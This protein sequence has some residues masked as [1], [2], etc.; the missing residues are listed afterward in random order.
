VDLAVQNGAPVVASS[1]NEPLIT[2]EWAVAVFKEAKAAGLTTGYVSNGNGTPQVLEYLRPWVDLYKV[3]LKSFDDRHY[4][5]LGGR[6]Q[7]ILDTISRLHAMD[8][9]VEIVTL[10]IPG[11]NDSHD[12]LMRLTSFVSSVSPD[13]PWHVTAF[14]GDYKMTDPENTTPEML[15]AA[16]D[17]GRANGLRHVYAGNLPGE[18]GDFEDT[19]CASCREPLVSR[20]GYHIRE[21]RITPDGRCPACAVAV[22]GRWSPQFDGQI[23]SRPFVPGSRRRLSLLNL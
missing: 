8:F 20:Y 21:Y 15:L 13:I 2:S 17:I 10:L 1:Y 9:W 4:R 23:A 22:P 6:L 3:D 14:H 11:F 16:A 18:V 19:H 7:P 5:T 12:E